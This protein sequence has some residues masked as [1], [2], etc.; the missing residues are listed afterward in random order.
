[1]SRGAPL[2]AL[3]QATLMSHKSA[4]KFLGTGLLKIGHH[5]QNNTGFSAKFSSFSL[6]PLLNHKIPLSFSAPSIPHNAQ[7]QLND[8]M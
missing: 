6:N 5:I 3:H 1:M 4:T 8:D 2:H 7:Q